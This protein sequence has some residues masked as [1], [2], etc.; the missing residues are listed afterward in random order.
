MDFSENELHLNRKAF[1]LR[2]FAGNDCKTVLKNLDKLALKVPE[3]CLQ[4]VSC[5][6]K[7]G[8]VHIIC[9]GHELRVDFEQKIA[10]FISACSELM[11]D[12]YPTILTRTFYGILI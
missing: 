8:E 10:D 5:F 12:I 9:F 11:Y 3:N 2:Q 6:K 4:Y 7:S 1:Q